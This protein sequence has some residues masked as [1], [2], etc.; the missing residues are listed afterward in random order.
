MY[1][2][3][4]TEKTLNIADEI[5][6]RNTGLQVSHH[7]QLMALRRRSDLSLFNDLWKGRY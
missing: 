5:L 6:I 7:E 3:N 4:D 2:L 1:A